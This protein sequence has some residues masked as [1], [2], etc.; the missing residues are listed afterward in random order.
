[1]GN[2]GYG[3]FLG[4]SNALA[5]WQVKPALLQQQISSGVPAEQYKHVSTAPLA[6]YLTL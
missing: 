3:A 5:V 2:Q 4:R 6:L 1:M